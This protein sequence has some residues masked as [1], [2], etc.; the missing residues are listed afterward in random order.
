MLK[1]V[2]LILGGLV[3]GLATGLFGG[4]GGMLAVPLLVYA[5]GKKGQVAHATAIA[6]I[7]PLTLVSSVVY[8]ISG[9]FDVSIGF[10]IMAGVIAGGIL[11]SLFLKKINGEIL[12]V[13]FSILMLIAGIKLCI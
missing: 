10:Y 11:G 6:V 12:A 9:S 1:K 13:I 2:I 8:I 7:L 3:T 5:G 4:G